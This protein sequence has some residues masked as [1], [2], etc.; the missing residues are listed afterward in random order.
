M[1]KSY[2]RAQYRREDGNPY[3]HDL[4]QHFIHDERILQSLVNATGVSTQDDVLEIGPGSGMLTA[5]LCRCAHHVIAVEAD[6]SI[7]PFLRLKL[8]SFNNYTLIH[9]DIRHQNLSQLCAPLNDDFFIIANIP[10]NITSSI[11]DLLLGS[12]LPIRQISVMVQKEVADKLTATPSTESY[13]L[14]SVRCQ[15]FC[16]PSLIQVLPAEAFTPPPKV[17]SAFVNLP[18]RKAPPCPVKDE[19][20]L[21]RLIR[22]GFGMRRKTLSNAVQSAG[23]LSADQVREVLSGLH[24]SPT[25]RGEALGIIEWI[26]FANA[27]KEACRS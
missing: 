8:E 19:A 2:Q 4:G 3:K 22:A 18:F 25:I 10:Y 24:L 1:K 20:L 26:H 15:Y 7:L 14:L 16:E 11:F 23:P 9:G 12:N 17:D 21:F 27:Y 5:C 13:G 6:D